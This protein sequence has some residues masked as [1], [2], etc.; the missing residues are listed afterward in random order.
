M[1]VIRNSELLV[2]SQ[3]AGILDGLNKEVIVNIYLPIKKVI[4]I[5]GSLI[6][7]PAFTFSLP[8]PNNTHISLWELLLPLCV[9]EFSPPEEASDRSQHKGGDR[10]NINVKQFRGSFVRFGAFIH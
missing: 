3:S 8:L 9:V 2:V 6:V 1:I 7:Y 10:S 4:Y 5:R